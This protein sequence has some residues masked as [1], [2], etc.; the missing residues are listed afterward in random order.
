MVLAMKKC[1]F[2]ASTEYLHDE[3]SMRQQ[4]TCGEISN[5]RSV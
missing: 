5:S 1:G 3:K 4:S 2:T